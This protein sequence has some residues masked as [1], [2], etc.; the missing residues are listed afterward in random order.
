MKI[1][2][3][4][5]NAVVPEICVD[6]A[7]VLHVFWEDNHISM[8]DVAV[9]YMRSTAT[10]IIP[11]GTN[12]QGTLVSPRSDPMLDDK[13]NGLDA[14]VTMNIPFKTVLDR[15]LDAGSFIKAYVAIDNRANGVINVPTLVY[16]DDVDFA[17]TE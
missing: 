6:S 16:K 4:G 15:T 17:V 5:V 14:G 3:L 13:C 11:S 8:N 7:D 2:D 1:A 10:E 9:Y 12:K